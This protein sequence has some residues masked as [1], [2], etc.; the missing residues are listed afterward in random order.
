M[1]SLRT[2][3]ILIYVFMTLLITCSVIAGIVYLNRE[4]LKRLVV[5]KLNSQLTVRV[6]VQEISLSF[7][8][9]FPLISLDFKQVRIG[10]SDHSKKNLLTANHVYISFNLY[11]ILLKRYAIRKIELDSGTCKLRLD[12]KGNAN[13]DIWNTKSDSAQETTLFS[14]K[15]IQVKRFTLYYDDHRNKQSYAAQIHDLTASLNRMQQGMDLKGMGSLLVHTCRIG[16]INLIRNQDV[17]TDFSITFDDKKHELLIHPSQIQISK[18]KLLA[19]GSV[20]MAHQTSIQMEINAR[21]GSL[22]E[23]LS[24]L[25]PNVSAPLH[26]YHAKGM[27]AFNIRANGKI[28]KNQSPGIDADFR[29][30]QGSFTEKNTGTSLSQINCSGKFSNGKNRNARTSSIDLNAFSMQLNQGRISGNARIQNLFNPQITCAIEGSMPLEA[31]QQ[32]IPSGIITQI[33]GTVDGKVELS[34]PVRDLSSKSGI[35]HVSNGWIS[36]HATDIM[37]QNMQTIQSLKLGL[38]LQNDQASIEILQLQSSDAD[39]TVEGHFSQ[40]FSSVFHNRPLE[41]NLKLK[42]S[43]IDVP[44]F[45]A[46]FSSHSVDTTAFTLPRKLNLNL[47]IQADKLKFN[48]FVASQ[49]SGSITYQ[50]GQLGLQQLKCSTMN[51]NIQLDGNAIQT[52]DGHFMVDIKS[53]MSQINLKSLFKSCAEFGQTEITS[54]HIDGT[55]HA[56]ISLIGVWNNRFECLTDKL[57]A[58]SDIR[59]RNGELNRYKP[60]ES[61]SKYANIEDL[62]NLRFNDLSNHILIQNRTIT[63]PEMEIT[64]NALNLSASGTHTFDQMVDYR[65]K[66]RLKELL[67][68]KRTSAENEFGEV[69]ETGKGLY[70]YLSMKGPASKPV[71]QYDKVAVKKKIKEDLK[72]EKESIREV[73]R[74]EFGLKK[75]SLIKESEKNSGELEFERD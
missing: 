8:A 73:L 50:S 36:L 46:L 61:L 27:V 7:F 75:D 11:D 20:N 54:E 70:L 29:I 71:I 32:F 6:D 59:I 60:L 74:K 19:Q 41:A 35:R 33:K 53:D 12:K 62:R 40:I 25:P 18:V 14:L 55:L 5:D 48:A 45:A 57:Y 21:S 49:V 17:I 52:N 34:G 28:G 66:I 24:L 58:E 4:K 68:K 69:D 63:I 16:D 47:G 15:S 51:G 56:K 22:E 31:L 38:R 2:K 13:F 39:V 44:L 30:D 37:L 9:Q 3:R 1:M 10:E 65:F 64:N 26:S 42:S 67:S 72:F 43:S 23:W